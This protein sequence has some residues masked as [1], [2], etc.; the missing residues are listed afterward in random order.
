MFKINKNSRT[1]KIDSN[2][3]NLT[4]TEFDL[5]FTLISKE[6]MVLKREELLQAIQDESIIVTD[7]VIDV[8]IK[9][10]RDKLLQYHTIIE[11]IHGVG[12]VCRKD[13]IP[14]NS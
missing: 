2:L 6:N 14:E 10:L 11:T 7:R 4:K 3:I 9:K 5:L 12:Y 13:N 8:H 1:V